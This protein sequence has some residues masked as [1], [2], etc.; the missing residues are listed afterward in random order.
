MVSPVVLAL[1]A[2]P[3]VARTREDA[4][5]PEHLMI[6]LILRLLA[7]HG[8]LRAV[9]IAAR[10]GLS[11]QALEPTLQF[12]RAERLLEVPRRGSFDADVSYQLTE[13]GR[14]R[15]ADAFE[16]CRYIGPA[17]VSL[18]DY[19]EQSALQG[20]R[21]IRVD[22]QRLSGAL[23]DAVVP[24]SLRLSLGAALNSGRS[25]YLYGASGTG[26][27]YLAERLV[28]AVDGAI[29]IPHAIHVHGEIIQLFDPLVHQRVLEPTAVS[30]LERSA[31]GDQRWVL[32][33]RPVVTMGGELS[34]EMLELRIERHG[35]YYIAPPQM[36]ANNGLLIIDD[37]GRQKVSVRELMN[38]WIV[39][40][41]RAVDYLSLGSGLKFEVPF[42][43][44]VIFSS[45]LAPDSVGDPAF[46]RRLSYKIHVGA[47]DE[48]GYREIFRQACDR[49]RVL[50]S[51]TCADFLIRDLHRASGLPL[52]PAVPSDLVNKL[53][54]RSAF[55]GEP[56]RIDD[57]SLRWAWDLY[58]AKDTDPSIAATLDD[59]GVNT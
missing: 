52:Y 20:I 4:G 13:S 16:R 44:R 19:L 39:P 58:F 33:R 1:P 12:L 37:L 51:D 25:I 8:V 56:V 47:L 3:P 32:V 5:L 53:V 9:A 40:L 27:T 21:D 34:L 26:K 17:P 55:L 45:N 15:A 6:E 36:K 23:G 46:L 31:G 10:L 35:G 11:L 50:H 7:T 57:E 38:R 24:E 2:N 18:D 54:D 49:A 22:V 43:L 14:L 48:T 30:A 42:D 59:F 29:R 28:G 41:D